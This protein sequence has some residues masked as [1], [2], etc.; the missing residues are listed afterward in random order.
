MCTYPKTRYILIFEYYKNDFIPYVT[1]SQLLHILAHI[2]LRNIVQC[3]GIN[4]ICASP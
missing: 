2:E 1:A 3:L 4:A